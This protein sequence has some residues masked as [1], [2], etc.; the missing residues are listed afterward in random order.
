[1]TQRYSARD[2][3]ERLVSFPTVSR[4]TNLPL[5]D[6]VEE[7]LADLGIASVRTPDETGQKASLHAIVGP[8]VEGGV[9]L[10]GH[11]DVVPID[12]QDWS[13]DPF[14]LTERDGKLYGRGTC[15]MKGWLA[16]SL[17]AVPR[18]LE[19]DLK[20][21][22]ILAFSYDEEVGCLGAPPMIA[23]IAS[24]LPQAAACIVGEPSMMKI[25]DGHKGIA[26]L[27]V[28]VRGF[29]VHSS[30]VHTGVSAIMTAARLITW[31][32]EQ[33]ARNAATALPENAAYEPPFTTLHSG[34]IS[35]G[36][37]HN[38]T[39]KDCRFSVDIRAVPNEP[40]ADW[41]ARFRAEAATVEA[42]IQAIRPEAKI[43]VT[44]RTTAPGL[45]P[46][47][48]GAAEALV[49]RLTG[50]NATGK[51][52]YAT[53]GGQFQDGGFS[54]VICGPGSI[55]QAHQPDEYLSVEQLAAG[56]AFMEKLVAELAR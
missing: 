55:E 54:T 6:F 2:M 34:M 38:I 18:M 31:L 11:T 24:E 3:L 56:E 36:T 37:A 50:E 32:H 15:D 10:S 27:Q 51:V 46:E 35:G 40:V 48:D 19:S 9:I 41:V 39:A 44:E 1:M 52:A 49:R 42:E 53:E 14:T 45:V 20:R 33:M 13:S 26:G 28:D 7:Y 17:A 47:E 12:G 5:I 30:L 22:A 4:D 8:E 21:P 29:E 43:T 23:R 16:L 25:V